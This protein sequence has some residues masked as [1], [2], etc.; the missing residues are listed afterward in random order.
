VEAGG[1]EVQSH[2]WKLREVDASLGYKRECLEEEKEGRTGVGVG[3]KEEKGEGGGGHQ[4]VKTDVS[5]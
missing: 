5:H 3:E 1:S 4:T 2:S